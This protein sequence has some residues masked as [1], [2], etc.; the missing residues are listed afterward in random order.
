[1]TISEPGTYSVTVLYNNST[2]T[3]TDY[4]EVEFYSDL[5]AGI[6]NNLVVCETTPATPFN[7]SLN[8]NVILNGLNSATHTIKYYLS[9]TDAEANANPITNLTDFQSTSNPQTIYYEI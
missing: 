5:T 1:I 9:Q 6:A 7:L 2:C 4:I 8:N 3:V